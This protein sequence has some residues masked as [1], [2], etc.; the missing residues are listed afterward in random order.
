MSSRIGKSGLPMIVLDTPRLKAEDKVGADSVFQLPASPMFLKISLAKSWAGAG[1][2]VQPNAG[3][4]LNIVLMFHLK[5][6]LL[7]V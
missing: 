5:M 6:P 4:I 1:S 7:A 2:G 3:L